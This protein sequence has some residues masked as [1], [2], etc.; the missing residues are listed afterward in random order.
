[1][2]LLADEDGP[3]VMAGRDVATAAVSALA[4]VSGAWCVR[5]HQAAGSADAVRV[6]RAWTTAGGR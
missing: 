1:G 6:A 2:D 3:R 4:A 5:V